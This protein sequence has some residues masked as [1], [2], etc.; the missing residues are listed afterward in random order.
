MAAELRVT[1]KE[2]RTSNNQQQQQQKQSAIDVGDWRF[3]ADIWSL[4]PTLRQY[5]LSLTA[6]NLI[7]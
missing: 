5:Q 4:P 7:Q 3:V 2:T 1:K 6:T